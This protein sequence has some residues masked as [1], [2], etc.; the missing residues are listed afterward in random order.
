MLPVG[1]SCVLNMP[2]FFNNFTDILYHTP[3]Y[4]AQFTVTTILSKIFE[5]INIALISWRLGTESLAAYA[6]ADYIVE[7]VILYSC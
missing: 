1:V 4:Y 5:G 3:P 6:V 7:Y 2:P